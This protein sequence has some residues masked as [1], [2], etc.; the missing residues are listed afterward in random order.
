MYKIYWLRPAAPFMYGG[1]M[2]QFENGW[3]EST[4]IGNFEDVIGIFALFSMQAGM[5]SG[6]GDAPFDNWSLHFLK[7]VW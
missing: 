3:N 4:L 7:F 6:P 2:G 1:D 5:P